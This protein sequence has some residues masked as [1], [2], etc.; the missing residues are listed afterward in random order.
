MPD[1]HAWPARAEIDPIISAMP[2]GDE[3]SIES[4]GRYIAAR[5]SGDSFRRAKAIHDY[6]ADRI[7]YDFAALKLPRIPDEDADAQIVWRNRKG[8]C[9]GY[10]NL[11]VAIAK[12]ADVEAMYLVGDARDTWGGTAPQSHAWN[13][14]K[15]DGR[16]LLVDAT[17]DAGSSDPSDGGETFHK[18]YRTLYLFTPP[19]VFGLDH[20]PADEGW[21]L[22]ANPLRH[23]DFLHQ[24]LLGPAFA[25]EGLELISPTQP[26]VSASGSLDVRLKNPRLRSLLVTA[27][28][29]SRPETECT[30]AGDSD[31]DAHCKFDQPG[32]WR[33]MLY[34]SA[35]RNENH[36]SVA[37]IEV[38]SQ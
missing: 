3:A 14:V 27:R 34:S 30:V 23:A 13:A 11:F 10:A 19:E 5:T 2:S 1:E 7:R 36:G 37:A 16:W 21:Q 15:V 31:L 38:N 24:P 33:V 20:F 17:W 35:Q 12:A 28:Q 4:I 32:P 9:A 8:V 22:R 25:A 18:R 29:G 26:Q 6:V